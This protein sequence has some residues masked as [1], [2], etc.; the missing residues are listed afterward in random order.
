M[1]AHDATEEEAPTGPRAP[2]TPQLQPHVLDCQDEDARE[3]AIRAAKAVIG[4]G[5]CLVMPTDTVYGICADAFDPRAVERLLHAKRR[6]RDM[7][8]P[9]LI[10]DAGVL[11]AL[12]SDVPPQARDLVEVYWPGPLTIICRAQSSLRMDLGET[13]GTIAIRVPDHDLA[14]DVLRRT[15]P[16]AVSS[17][18]VSGREAA[19]SVAE[20]TEQLGLDVALYLDG[21]P[22]AGAQPSTI[23]DFTRFAEGEVVREGALSLATLRETLPDLRHPDDHDPDPEVQQR[24]DEAL[25]DDPH[26]ERDEDG[27]P[28]AGTSDVGTSDVGTQDGVAT[29]SD[30]VAS[31]PSGSHGA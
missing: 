4:S 30:D 24:L 29:R 18:N 21:G 28:D 5:Q 25:A 27:T 1:P 6:G 15:G 2:S 20:A 11:A 26:E 10:G 9:V 12:A 16:L 13:R 7:P 3:E 17:A 19:T 23:I 14:R 31:D 22:T 8:P